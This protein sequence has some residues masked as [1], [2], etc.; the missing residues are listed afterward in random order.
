MSRFLILTNIAPTLHFGICKANKKAE[1]LVRIYF[2]FLFICCCCCCCFLRFLWIFTLLCK[3][4]QIYF[5]FNFNLK[6]GFQASLSLPFSLCSFSSFIFSLICQTLAKFCLLAYFS[7]LN[8]VCDRRFS[9]QYI[10]ITHIPIL[11]MLVRQ[12]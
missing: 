4:F 5:C 1:K 10:R 7:L 12:I 3:W 6:D 11:A 8:I 9:W 2:S